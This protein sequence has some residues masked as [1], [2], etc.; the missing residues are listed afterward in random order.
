MNMSQQ[1][2]T[3]LNDLY[4]LRSN[5]L[6]DLIEYRQKIIE[7][8]GIKENSVKVN[9]YREI[10]NKLENKLFELDRDILVRLDIIKE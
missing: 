10:T 8:N 2:L 4:T 7:L 9:E 6:S 5:I 1:Y 3:Y